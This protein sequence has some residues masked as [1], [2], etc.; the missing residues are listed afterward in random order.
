MEDSVEREVA[1]ADGDDSIIGA[2]RQELREWAG[3]QA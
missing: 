2:L 3:D 1:S